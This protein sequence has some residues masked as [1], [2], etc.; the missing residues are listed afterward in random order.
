MGENRQPGKKTDKT[1]IDKPQQEQQDDFLFMKEVIKEKPVNKK[2][3][4]IRLGLVAASAVLFGSLAAVTF[5]LVRPAVEKQVSSQQEPPAVNIPSD[6]PEG[7][8]DG[9]SGESTDETGQTEAAEESDTA[10]KV[11]ESGTDSGENNQDGAA[12][13][14]NQNKGESSDTEETAENQMMSITEYENVYTEMMKIADEAKKS[15]V[16]VIGIT[17]DVDWFN[18]TYENQEQSAGVI[19]ADNGKQMFILTQYGIIKDVDRIMVTLADETSVEAKYL[20]HDPDT[21]FTIITVEKTG[22]SAQTKSA[23]STAQLGNSYGTAQG[24]QVIALGSPMG[25]GDSVAFGAITSV[26]NTVAT[27]DNQYGLLNTDII[28]S[29]DG[30]GVI[31]D[32]EGKVI[33]VIT[34]QYNNE[35]SKNIITALP[36]SQLKQL[37]ETLSNN[38]EINYVGINGQ[39]VTDEINKNTDMPKGVWV[40]SVEA[41]SPAMQATIQAGDIIIKLGDTQVENLAQYHAALIKLKKDEVVP[42]VIMRQGTE[43]YVEISIDVTIGA[44]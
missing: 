9:A 43:G 10:D 40:A 17:D 27:I 37:I 38:K 15:Q 28:G 13:D 3:L 8:A 44:L 41:D 30:T 32:L 39:D 33:G 34:Q 24:E 20:K 22:L 14:S 16:T 19:V 11:G 23:V 36:I 18:K 7:I 12:A 25:Y 29:T 4:V 26:K 2:A 35:H 21:G 5:A 42:V 31:V 6:S 1:K